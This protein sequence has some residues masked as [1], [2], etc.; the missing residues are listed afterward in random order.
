MATS[1]EVELREGKGEAEFREALEV[2]KQSGEHLF[3]GTIARYVLGDEREP[4]KV[5]RLL[6]WRESIMPSGEQIER[7]LGALGKELVLEVLDAA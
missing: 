5:Q 4:R 3:E 7:A 1:V 2:I 6:I